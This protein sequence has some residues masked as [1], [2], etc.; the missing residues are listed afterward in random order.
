MTNP[1]LTRQRLCLEEQLL[2]AGIL[3]TFLWRF[4]A[5]LWIPAL[6]PL[7]DYFPMLWAALA[8]C[9]T[10]RG[11]TWRRKSV[12][13]LGAGLGL[14]FL[15]C[16]FG[17]AETLQGGLKAVSAGVLAFGVCYQAAFGLRKEAL[18]SF[19]RL[20]L[21]LWTA[22]A[23]LL[24]LAGLWAA[25]YD[26]VLSTP[27]G[28]VY[29][30][31]LQDNRLNL[32]TY[33]TDSASLL[34]LSLVAAVTGLLMTRRAPGRV[35]YG[36]ACVVL[37]VTLSL[38]VT[39]TAFITLGL[40][41][42]LVAA[43]AALT[44]LRRLKRVPEWC[45]RLL[46]LLLAL[47]LTIGV[48]KALNHTLDLFN[49]AKVHLRAAAEETLVPLEEAETPVA[50]IPETEG[51]ESEAPETEDAANVE[52][53]SQRPIQLDESIL[54]GRQYV[55]L[56]ALQVLQSNPWYL[57]YGISVVQPMLLVN[58]LTGVELSYYHMHCMY[59]QVLVECG[60]PGLILL[61]MFLWRFARCAWK[62]MLD[63]SK[64]LWMRTLPVLPICILV[65]ELVECLTLLTFNNP[66][67][68]FLLLFMGMTVR[69]AEDPKD[70]FRR[71]EHA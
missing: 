32:L 63:G 25:L 8:A 9:L 21:G 31:G 41:L 64:P 11:Q 48:Y 7:N 5:M 28:G 44:G 66:V 13:I 15:R 57:L 65:A 70:L 37:F 26:Q 68:P 56:G 39:R 23:T 49:S 22:L 30:L 1:A 14:I 4:V 17:G 18:V 10:C 54:S 45:S 2:I 67:L 46:C 33:C 24:S 36:L 69:F 20:L 27:M 62:L 51:G 35:L 47:A 43:C 55:W 53:L 60:I 34:T 3:F 12:W 29:V 52:T 71:K 58:P 40:S 61:L 6:Y 19:L 16:L 50:E 38:T 59:L 42:G